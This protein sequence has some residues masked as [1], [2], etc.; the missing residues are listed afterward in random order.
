MAYKG[1]K[2]GWS[3][4][5]TLRTPS[6]ATPAPDGA[7]KLQVDFGE[8]E[9]KKA[10][11]AGYYTLQFSLTSPPNL[12]VGLLL[13]AKAE[14]LWAVE[15]NFVR[16]EVQVLNG[17]AVSGVGQSVSIKLIDDSINNTI[18]GNGVEYTA[19]VQ[20]AKGTRPSIQHPPLIQPWVVDEVLGGPG[21]VGFPPY[22]I[23][24]TE[25]NSMP[26]PPNAGITSVF[27]MGQILSPPLVD[28]ANIQFEFTANEVQLAYSNWDILNTWVPLPP[29][30]TQIQCTNGHSA[31]I[32]VTPIYGIEG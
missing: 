4:S 1:Y 20:V 25:T 11:G 9:D 16:R 2:T 10:L 22:T 12:E 18:S 32:R 3:A 27:L 19:N 26:V 28:P 7:V 29:G 30:T 15:G 23:A 24:P 5:G 17:S 13:R 8:S 14:I 31:D 21:A 6:T